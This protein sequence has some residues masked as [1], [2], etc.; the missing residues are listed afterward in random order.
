MLQYLVFVGVGIN[1]VGAIPYIRETLRGTTKPNRVT[2]LMWSIAPLIATAAAFSDGIRLATLPVFMAGIMPLTILA[3]SFINKEAYWKLETFDYLCGFFSLTALILWAITKEPL[4]AIFFA[5]IGDFFAAIPT[6]VKSWRH[7]ETETASA[8][9]A[10][11]LATLTSFFAIT[12]WTFSA[13]AFPLYLVMINGLVI[14]AIYKK[15]F[16]K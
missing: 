12:L 14:L 5:I 9:V 4:V 2:W 10:S 13:Y 8:Y 1:L 3:A 6:L 15:K 11:L 16:I 7:P